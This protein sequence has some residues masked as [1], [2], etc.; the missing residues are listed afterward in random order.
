MLMA[1]RCASQRL[2]PMAAGPP[3]CVGGTAVKQSVFKEKSDG[4]IR[5]T[6]KSGR[7]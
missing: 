7:R 4:R 6:R 3:G 5:D 1:L 2:E